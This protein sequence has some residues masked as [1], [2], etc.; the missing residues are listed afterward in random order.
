MCVCVCLTRVHVFITHRIYKQ[1]LE[2]QE[3]VLR[4]YNER[5]LNERS[6][7]LSSWGKVRGGR[8]GGGGEGRPHRWSVFEAELSLCAEEPTL[9]DY[10]AYPPGR[11]ALD[12]MRSWYDMCKYP[13]PDQAGANA[14]ARACV[15]ARARTHTHTTHHTHASSH[16]HTHRGWSGTLEDLRREER[17]F[18][19]ATQAKF[20]KKS[21]DSD[22]T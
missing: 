22:F 5:A 11:M 2:H 18:M 17:E 21:K 4:A 12:A 8:E 19:R 9:Q 20:L 14:Q 10:R 13:P 7:N 15:R 16:T 1:I 3:A 6:S